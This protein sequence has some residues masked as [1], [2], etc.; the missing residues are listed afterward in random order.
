MMPRK[1]TG[2]R[3]G[4][5]R[6]TGPRTAKGMAAVRANLA[7]AQDGSAPW[8]HGLHSKYLRP[9]RGCPV[10]DTCEHYVAEGRCQVELERG[11]ALLQAALE[12]A[13][14]DPLKATVAEKFVWASLLLD[15]GFAWL[16]GYEVGRLD[17]D[18]A[19]DLQPAVVKLSRVLKDFVGFASE[20]GLTPASQAAVQDADRQRNLEAWRAAIV[21][22]E[23]PPSGLLPGDVEA[24]GDAAE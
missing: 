20:L 5:P 19:A 11:M 6:K 12:L 9:C 1:P 10:A 24:T 21:E 23:E 13:E 3:P 7:A 15:R 2:R 17:K 22:V 14:G 16:A 4:R 18:G 8:R